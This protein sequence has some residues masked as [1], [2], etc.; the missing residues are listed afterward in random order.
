MA[1]AYLLIES[2]SADADIYS[3]GGDEFFC[4]KDDLLKYLEPWY[5]DE[6]HA[7]IDD[8]GCLYKLSIVTGAMQLKM[9]DNSDGM[10]EFFLSRLKAFIKEFPRKRL[11]YAM[12]QVIDSGPISVLDDKELLEIICS[13]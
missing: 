1:K 3:M 13:H 8:D 2:G 12:T 10:R 6:N 4:S 5:V 7:V 9:A 11:T